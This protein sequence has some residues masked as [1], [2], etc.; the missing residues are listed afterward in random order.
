[1]RASRSTEAG[2]ILGRAH[3]LQEGARTNR[4]DEDKVRAEGEDAAG[5]GQRFAAETSSVVL[6]EAERAK[7][8]RKAAD[9]TLTGRQ[10]SRPDVNPSQRR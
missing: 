5:A 2:R 6:D 9:D 7:L 3:A 4:G 1:M 10:K 8:L